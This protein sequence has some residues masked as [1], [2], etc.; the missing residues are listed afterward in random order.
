[1]VDFLATPSERSL[2]ADLD[3]I[4]YGEIYQVEF[5]EG[6]RKLIRV[7]R[8]VR[9]ALLAIRATGKVQKASIHEC[10]ITMIEYRTKAPN[11][12]LR[13]TKKMKF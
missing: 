2:V 5:A 10:R 12:G 9:D 3:E 6:E 1:M 4:G 13:C 11:T 8:K 7:D